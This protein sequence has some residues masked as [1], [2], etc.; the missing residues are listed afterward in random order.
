DRFSP[1]AFR[2]TDAGR[3]WT[4]I[5]RGIPADEFVAVVRADRKQRGLLYA[6]TNR[7][8][9]V[10]FDDG[11]NWQ[12]LDRGLPTTW[13]RDLLPHHDDL[14]VAAQG[15]G[16][17]TLDDVSPL[18]AIAAGA[19]RDPVPRFPPAPAVRLRTSESHDTPPPPETPLGRNPPT[20]AV[21]DY[22][23]AAPAPGPV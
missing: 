12:P 13:M 6:G 7:A 16:I 4:G 14:S 3:T 21:I 15:R 2:T 1:L 10:S 18:R 9:Y 20:G 8:V 23:L 5:T 11:G 22:W 19:T 17:W